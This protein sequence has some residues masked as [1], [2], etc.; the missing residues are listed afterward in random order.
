MDGTVDEVRGRIDE[1]ESTYLPASDGPQGQ[2][3]S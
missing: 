3:S 2:A 1:V